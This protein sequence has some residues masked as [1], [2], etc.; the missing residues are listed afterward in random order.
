MEVYLAQHGE[1]TPKQFDPARPLTE[2]GTKAVEKV[3]VLAARLGLEVSQ[4][5]HS[6]KTRSRQTAEILGATLSP[7]EGVVGV[8]GLAPRDDVQ[9]VA[10]ALE[11]EAQPVMLV[12]H[13]P[14]LARLAGLLLTG[15][16]NNHVLSFR[17]GGIVCL[18]HDQDRWQVAW[19]LTPEMAGVG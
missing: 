2:Q 12:G 5:R 11:S 19:I 8:P 7:A 15:D 17:T 14:F 3:A 16:A 6:G 1:A 10:Q 13:L 4:I 18:S 9:P